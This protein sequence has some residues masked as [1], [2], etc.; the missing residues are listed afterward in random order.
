MKLLRK[1]IVSVFVLTTITFAQKPFMKHY[2]KAKEFLQSSQ[3]PKAIEWY[4]KS[5]K[6]N[7][8]FDSA[9]AGMGYCYYMS[10]EY[11]QALEN[12]TKAV[13][14]SDKNFNSNYYLGLTYLKLQQ[15]EKATTYLKKAVSL[16]SSNSAGYILLAELFYKKNDY[17]NSILYYK[18]AARMPDASPTTYYNLGNAYYFDEDYEEAIK[19]Y[20]VAIKKK[21]RNADYHYALGVAYLKNADYENAKTNF[22]LAAQYNRAKYDKILDYVNFDGIKFKF[23]TTNFSG[24]RIISRINNG[25]RFL[26][27]VQYTDVKESVLNDVMKLPIWNDK[28][29][30]LS[31]GGTVS[32]IFNP[33][34]TDVSVFYSSFD[35]K[36]VKTKFAL[37]PTFPGGAISTKIKMLNY[38]IDAN[39]IPWVFWGKIFNEY[40]IGF[41]RNQFENSGNTLTYN[42]L[43][44]SS[45]LNYRIKSIMIGGKV[46]YNTNSNLDNF[47]QFH[48][49]LWL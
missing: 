42:S 9:Y 21:K 14:L 25:L 10:N 41:S 44:I 18:K 43:R 48:L 47:Y 30:A 33:F 40:G 32:Y 39:Y 12:F 19:A 17:Q 23:I 34:S 8:D 26:P 5:I 11:Q 37:P 45:S 4:K 15:N 29:K 38:S 24:N 36:D 16:D 46:I 22:L 6:A 13:S 7:P 1:I 27:G 31:Y 49:G 35:I 20:T 2:L 28:A 3:Y